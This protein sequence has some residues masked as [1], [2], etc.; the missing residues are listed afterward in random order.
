MVWQ[1][2]NGI[3]T[4]VNFFDFWG[5]K[6][7]IEPYFLRD[8]AN[9]PAELESQVSG[10]LK[11]VLEAVTIFDDKLLAV[12]EEICKHKDLIK[13]SKTSFLLVDCVSALFKCLERI[14]RK[15]AIE[16][17]WADADY[18]GAYQITRTEAFLLA[19]EEFARSRKR[20]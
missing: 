7:K 14:D 9:D 1:R 10:M 18:E 15:T 12:L 3:Q 4:A 2:S 6:L 8:G 17:P 13:L 20:R 16:N 19:A 11:N 5:A